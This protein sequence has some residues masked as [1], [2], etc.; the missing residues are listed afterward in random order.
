MPTMAI[1]VMAFADKLKKDV[2]SKLTKK[3]RSHHIPAESLRRLVKENGKISFLKQKCCSSSPIRSTS[4]KTRFVILINSAIYIYDDQTST[5]P[6]SCIS[7]LNYNCVRRD[8]SNKSC[9]WAFVIAAEGNESLQIF[10]CDS[11]QERLEWMRKIKE[12]MYIAKNVDFRKMSMGDQIASGLLLSDGQLIDE[13][14]YERLESPIFRDDDVKIDQN[15]SDKSHQHRR[16]DS[17]LIDDE[18]KDVDHSQIM[19]DGFKSDNVFGN[20]NK[21]NEISV[22]GD[23]D[24]DDDSYQVGSWSK[25]KRQ[26]AVKRRGGR[27]NGFSTPDY[28]KTASQDSFDDLET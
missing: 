12:N 8:D 16:D 10:S 25:L 14:E 2:I 17:V 11:D 9:K 20:S 5:C 19:S 21:D 1:D 27:R 23:E 3:S 24:D 28:F 13:A 4:W 15:D 6:R 22:F 18:E 26:G 7:L